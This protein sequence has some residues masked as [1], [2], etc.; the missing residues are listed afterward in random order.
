[1][2]AR[3]PWCCQSVSL[4]AAQLLPFSW[5]VCKPADIACRRPTVHYENLNQ[6]DDLG[7]GVDMTIYISSE[8]PRDQLGIYR[9]LVPYPDIDVKDG[10]VASAVAD[11]PG[12]CTDNLPDGGV[13]IFLAFPHGH[14][15]TTNVHLQHFRRGR[16]L[17]PIL[18]TNY[19]DFNKQ[20][21][22]YLST[23]VLPG[24]QF[25]LTCEMNNTLGHDVVGGVSTADEMCVAFLVYYPK[26]PTGLQAC[27]SSS[28]RPGEAFCGE[29]EHMGARPSLWTDKFVVDVGDT[30][31]PDDYIPLPL[32]D[33]QCNIRAYAQINDPLAW[34]AWSLAT[35]L[36][37]I[38]MLVIFRVSGLLLSATSEK[39]RS[40]SY[41][42]QANIKVYI[43]ALVGLTASFALLMGGGATILAGKQQIIETMPDGK[44]GAT[45]ASQ[46]AI[47]GANLVSLV[48]LF[49]LI[50]KPDM[51]W[52]LVTHHVV[53]IAVTTVLNYA[54]VDTLQT[55]WAQVGFVLALH[56]ATEQP[57]YI[58]L[59]VKRFSAST[60]A[61]AGS[62]Y[63]VCVYTLA[64]KTA[65]FV[66]SMFLLFSLDY[67]SQPLFSWLDTTVWPEVM[68]YLLPILVI[69][70]YLI[71]LWQA[72]ILY[73][74]G[75]GAANAR[76][77][78]KGEAKKVSG[79]SSATSSDISAGLPSGTVRMVATMI[80]DPENAV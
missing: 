38:G 28:L 68:R 48:F 19:F 55:A 1:M 44:L 73:A 66:W 65:I 32:E 45:T 52:S 6:L 2:R 20:A 50:A 57:V 80:V 33:N 29:D 7:P 22:K 77:G 75:R 26:V 8:P 39:Y 21:G 17:A 41:R 18:S 74:I 43:V 71:Q 42:H 34:E 58:A 3:A 56:A 25:R 10:E 35:V 69:A 24:D 36:L 67:S 76:A 23:R 54:F 47:L 72:W 49:E 5:L 40:M 51:N 60:A 79:E 78:E 63:A 30:G 37:L 27:A 15:T 53:T 64:S 12:S 11:C 16:E 70:L 31:I 62:F 13:T 46:M 14:L 61:A 9:V 4:S 59:L